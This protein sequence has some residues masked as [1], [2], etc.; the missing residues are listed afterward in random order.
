M[1]KKARL[2]TWILGMGAG[3]LLDKIIWDRIE[4]IGKNE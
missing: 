3:Y 2:L 1:K 4:R